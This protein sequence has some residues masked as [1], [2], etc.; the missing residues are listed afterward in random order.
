MTIVLIVVF[1]LVV[2]VGYA[3]PERSS[4]SRFE[5]ER[6]AAAGDKGAKKVLAREK[7]LPGVLLI[8]NFLLL[9]LALVF[10]GVAIKLY[11]LVAALFISGLAAI[12]LGPIGKIR[13]LQ[14]LVMRGYNRLEPKL[15]DFVQKFAP[16]LDFFQDLGDETIK[17]TSSK[18]ELKH[19]IEALGED[20]LSEGE[21]LI[22]L[23]A[24]GFS[25]KRVS[26]ILVPVK[27]VEFVNHDEVLG[28]LVLDRL[29]KTGLVTF[30]VIDGDKN[31]VVGILNIR[32][33]LTTDVKK[34]LMVAKAM[35]P[36]VPYIR[37]DYD[38]EYA[39]N[40]F[41]RSGQHY[42]IVINKHRE[43]VGILTLRDLMESLLGKELND[44]FDADEDAVAVAGRIPNNQPKDH[45]DV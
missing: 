21:Q 23:G 13:T 43:T 32:N 20:V 5:L 36:K 33:L 39:L 26:D 34:S 11:G 42:L 24:L 17:K 10:I 41:I 27:N 12:C 38:L 25:S 15:L 45:I 30:P 44:G 31:H 37:E 9:L 8:K 14:R 4:M 2:L 19:Q 22:I 7:Y 18:E 35:N 3:R 29:H 6:R 16:V 1:L 28:P 40:A